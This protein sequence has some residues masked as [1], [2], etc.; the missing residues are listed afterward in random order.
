MFLWELSNIQ[1][2]R[3]DVTNIIKDAAGTHEKAVN[4]IIDDVLPLK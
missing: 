2:F 4:G 1:M 3:F